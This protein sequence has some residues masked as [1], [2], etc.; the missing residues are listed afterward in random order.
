M[1]DENGWVEFARFD[2]DLVDAHEEADS[3]ASDIDGDGH[4]VAH[5]VS[6]DA[7]VVECGISDGPRWVRIGE[8]TALN[9]YTYVEGLGS[10]Y[11]V[12]QVKY[13]DWAIEK[14]VDDDE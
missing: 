8:F 2:G 10:D 7:I 13:G 14:Q 6:Q 11:R 9:Q 1:V 12:V 5:D 4:R 3:L